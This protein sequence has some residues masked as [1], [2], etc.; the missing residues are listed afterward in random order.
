MPT[1]N[2]DKECDE[3]ALAQRDEAVERLQQIIDW[4]ETEPDKQLHVRGPGIAE[5]RAFLKR[6][7]DKDE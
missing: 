4:W 2:S 3:L 1:T 5:A 7:E 6:L